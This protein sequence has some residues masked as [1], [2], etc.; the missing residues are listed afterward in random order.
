MLVKVGQR[1]RKGDPLAT[2]NIPELAGSVEEAKAAAA[3]SA[4]DRDNVYSGVRKEEVERT[5]QNVAIAE[6]NLVLARQQYARTADLASRGIDSQQQLDQV[7]SSVRAAE[8]SLAL[9]RSADAENKAGPT[10]AERDS[11]DAKVILAKAATAAV[12]ARLNKGKTRI[13]CRRSTA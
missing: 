11:A 8:A 7:V 10:K 13:C 4:A 3:K 5:A 6:S 2:L 12:E 9:F 1:V